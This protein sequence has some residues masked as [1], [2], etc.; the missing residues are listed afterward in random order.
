MV[1]IPEQSGYFQ[2]PMQKVY[3][4][5]FKKHLITVNCITKDSVDKTIKP[6]HFGSL[7]ISLIFLE[8]WVG[9]FDLLIDRIKL[10]EDWLGTVERQL[11]VECKFANTFS[12]TALKK[13]Q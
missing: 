3:D 11:Y 4:F 12:R 7:K 13:S 10:F 9:K 1:G 2:L 8:A 6:T 5:P